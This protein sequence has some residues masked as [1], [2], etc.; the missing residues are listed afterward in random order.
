MTAA[1]T[2]TLEYAELA[3]DIIG[4]PQV[5]SRVLPYVDVFKA[6]LAPEGRPAGVFLLLGPTGTGKTH[7]VEML[8]KQLHG[9]SRHYLR[10]DCG[11][12][13]MDHEVAKLIGAPPGYL[14]HRETQP[15]FNQAKVRS[16]TSERCGAAIVLLDEVEKAAPSLAKLLL[17]IMDRGILR[18]GDNSEVNFDRAFIFMT[19]NVGADEILKA[20][21][22]RLG[23]QE[24]DRQPITDEAIMKA[25]R[26][27]LRKRFTPEFLN[28]IDEQIPFRLLEEDSLR[29]IIAVLE[30][31]MEHHIISRLGAG[32]F[33][34]RLEEP[35]IRSLLALH[36]PR[37]GAREIKR[38]L[39]RVVL[40]SAARMYVKK[41]IPA[42]ATL[43]I[44]GSV[45]EPEFTIAEA[46]R[47]GSRA[48]STA[49]K[50]VRL[51]AAKKPTYL[52]LDLDP[53]DLDQA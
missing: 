27:A 23:F 49:K 40:V 37:W 33:S 25:A 8:A 1:R 22:E 16:F 9:N 12:F 19:S 42:G 32:S 6:H 35:F 52:G 39:N 29:E 45:N 28:R 50:F 15:M 46:T 44:S 11:E 3:S 17:G 47:I 7:F 36:S 43:V 34:L 26:G 13:Q 18:L 41:E 14:G 30:N 38:T 4:Q 31:N 24:G 20:A 53:E 10:V 5:L 48:P 21:G 2:Q 51:A